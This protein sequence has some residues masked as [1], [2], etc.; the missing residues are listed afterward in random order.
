MK[1]ALPKTIYLKDYQP[2][3]YQVEQTQLTIKLFEGYCEVHNHMIIRKNA[4]VSSSK[5]HALVLDGQEIALESVVLDEKKLTSKDY[6]VDEEQL[7]LHAVPER[8]ELKIIG[9][10]KPEDN[11]ALEGLYTSGSMYCTQCE[12][13]GFRRITYY[14]DRPDNMALFT[15]RIEANRNKYPVLLS[16]GNLIES[17]ELVQGRHFATWHDPFPKPCYLFAMVAGKLLEK[18]D[19]FIT[20][21]GREILLK[22]LVEPHNIDKCDFAMASL[23]RA[24]KWDEVTYGREYD[25]ELFHIVAVDAFNMGAMENKSLNIFNSSCVLAKPEITTDSTFE[26]IDSIIAH[27][28][29]HNWSG[30]RVT[31]RD[32][33]QLSLKEGF[34]VFRDAQYTEDTYS[35]IVKRIDDA[36]IMR[37]LQFAEDAGPMAHPIRPDAFIEISNFY[38]ITVY[39]KGA[40]VVRMIRNILGSEMFRKGSDLYFDRHDGQ[41]VTT[42]DFIK[43]MEDAS[44]LDLSLFSRWYHQAGTPELHIKDEYDEDL[45]RYRLFVRQ[46]CPE[47]PG[48][49]IKQPFHIPLALGLLNQRGEEVRLHPSK[50]TQQAFN[51]TTHVINVTKIEETFEFEK[52]DE[53]PLPS[54]LRDFSAPVKVYYS[55]TDAS[56]LRL[57]SQDSDSFNRW[58][59]SQ[60]LGRYFIFRISEEQSIEPLFIDYIDALSCVIAD[61]SLDLAAKAYILT[62]PSLSYLL[63]SVE[64]F[65]VLAIHGARVIFEKRIAEA[66]KSQF[67]RLFSDLNIQ[68]PYQ[69]IQPQMAQRRLK[70]TVLR[71]LTKTSDCHQALSL[72][73]TLFYETDNMTDQT[74]GLL[75]ILDSSD[76]SLKEKVLKE[77]YSQWQYED[78]VI[79][80]WFRLQCSHP[81]VGNLDRVQHLLAH[82]QFD[83]KNPNKVRSV[84]GAFANNMA[85][86]HQE[87]GSGYAFLAQK[88]CDLDKINPQI[89]SRMVN[90]LTQAHRYGDDQ[91]KAMVKQL[92][93]IKSSGK[94]SSD[95][96]EVVTKALEFPYSK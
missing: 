68:E 34:T 32:W 56:L 29:F 13:E 3:L 59:A 85:Q 77:F 55:Y 69:P 44:G 46:S 61:K 27:E 83:M 93:Y 91:A 57:M 94:L 52:L 78:L 60:R 8:F 64:K 79:L 40:E 76:L 37:T 36:V 71:Y 90:P 20:A 2:P 7:V 75:A 82:A 47:T 31:C 33:F 38:T 19:T 39:E 53:K 73:Q 92:E 10:I 84:I 63:N 25:L 30:N 89:A 49:K 35:K 74:Y 67:Y 48:Q 72:A 17:G 6:S 45:K 51:E 50:M 80:D 28:Y 16:N 4:N 15:T 87:D 12:A 41:A 96:F 81:D 65:N 9:R 70:G 54:L 58:D 88:V 18:T 1:E 42:E 21:S 95:L 14:I 5:N 11:T 62:A 22:I 26:R 24:M 66:L 23:K 86:F 43:A